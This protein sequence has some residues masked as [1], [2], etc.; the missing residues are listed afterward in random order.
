ME[1]YAK[2][3]SLPHCFHESPGTHW[4]SVPAL[5]HC[6]SWLEHFL[7]FSLMA[8]NFNSSF[9]GKRRG[10]PFS[11]VKRV[12]PSKSTVLYCTYQVL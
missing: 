11:S 4:N 5:G 8:C 7:A 12:H 6:K 9:P 10:K 2:W 3:R 1:E